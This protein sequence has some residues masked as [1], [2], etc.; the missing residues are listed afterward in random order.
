MQPPVASLPQAAALDP[1]KNR[2]D[3]LLLQWEQKMQGV[4]SLVAVLKRTD[5]DPV[6][7][8]SEEYRGQ[9]KFMRPNRAD[10]VVQ[11]TTNPNQYERFLCTG[12]YIFQFL[13]QQKEIRAHPI[14][15]R[16]AGQPALENSF[17]GFLA[18]MTAVEAKRR[19][20]LTLLK[21]D[22]H[23][24]YFEVKPRLLEDQAEFSI[25]RIAL[26][27]TT[28]MPRE[29]QFVAPKGDVLKW[30]IESIDINARVSAAD[31]ATPRTPPGWQMQQ[32]PPPGAPA[33]PPPP[34]RVR[35]QGK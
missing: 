20:D 16:A 34:T 9:L 4:Q 17:V 26:L 23:Y 5:I 22:Q 18:G 15:Q 3:A 25:A 13:P 29:M 19:F 30:D 21:E 31:F 10:L 35:P 2:L 14:P 11:K 27:Q 28:M 32:M 7:R 1:Q 33:A 8:T 24:A 6:A 12:N